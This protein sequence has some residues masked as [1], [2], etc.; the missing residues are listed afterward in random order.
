MADTARSKADEKEY[1]DSAK[2][3]DAKVTK[4]A[5]L[6]KCS[7]HFV[8]FTGPQ[9]F[10]SY[11]HACFVPHITVLYKQM[12]VYPQVAVLQTLEVVWIQY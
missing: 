2:E 12:L 8:A 9:L 6:I 4:L 7:K 5:E 3:L 1:F 10:I 11:F